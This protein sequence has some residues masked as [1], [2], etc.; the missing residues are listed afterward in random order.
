MEHGSTLNTAHTDAPANHRWVIGA[1][2]I[3]KNVNNAND[4]A[5]NLDDWRTSVTAMA[6]TEVGLFAF[7]VV[8]GIARC[9]SR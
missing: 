2:V 1:G 9:C 4:T 5:K 8:S 3:T 6:W 7:L